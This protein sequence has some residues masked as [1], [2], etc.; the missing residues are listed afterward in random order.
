MDA[1]DGDEAHDALLRAFQLAR[2]QQHSGS[3]SRTYSILEE[4]L[5]DV[6]STLVVTPISIIYQ[7]QTEIAKH[8]P[9]LRVLIYHGR[10]EDRQ[11]RQADARDVE[12]VVRAKHRLSSEIE[13][14]DLTALDM[15]N[16]DVVLTTYETLRQE[17]HYGKEEAGGKALRYAKRYRV[18]NTPLLQCRWWRVVLDEAQ[19]AEHSFSKV[20]SRSTS[21][22]S[23]SC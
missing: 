12:N 20:S 3:G 23:G 14:R 1:V 4:Q 7:W 2:S 17:V 21:R 8:A 10:K 15:V 18:P 22:H 13:E 5:L 16:A 6:Q 11:G 19:L 9:S